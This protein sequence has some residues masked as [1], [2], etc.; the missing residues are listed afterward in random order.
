L[1]KQLIEFFEVAD[2]KR[3]AKEM[4]DLMY[5]SVDNRRQPS[6]N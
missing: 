5:R 1:E 3:K 4:T 6:P 2:G